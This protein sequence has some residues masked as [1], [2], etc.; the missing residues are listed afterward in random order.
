MAQLI[1]LQSR[2]QVRQAVQ[3]RMSRSYS[4][5]VVTVWPSCSSSSWKGR[6]RALVLPVFRGLPIRMHTRMEIPPFSLDWG[7]SPPKRRE[8]SVKNGRG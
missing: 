3:G 2:W 8:L 4:Q 1:P 7:T 5:W 6:R